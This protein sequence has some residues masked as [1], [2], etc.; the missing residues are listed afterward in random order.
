MARESVRP[1]GLGPPGPGSSAP[2]RPPGRP[3]STRAGRAILEAALDAFVEEGY[4]GMS[5]EDVAARAGVGKTTLYRR[6]P[7]K[8]D[9]LLAAIESLLEDFHVDDTGDV[10]ADLTSAVRQAHHFITKTRAGD[11]LPRMLPEVTSRTPLGRAYAE[12]IMGPRAEAARRVIAGAKARGELRPD[13]DDQLAVATMVGS[14]I[15][16]RVT[17]T[18]PDT[19]DA[20][21][22]RLV[23]QLLDGMA[24][25]G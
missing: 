20:L 7:C 25:A 13:L 18:L 23:G 21:A 5:M 1:A 6:W 10:R 24:A 12:R 9:L 15:F 3:R 17:S 16:M 22:E 19:G 8:D 2:G 14:L 4:Q 11:V